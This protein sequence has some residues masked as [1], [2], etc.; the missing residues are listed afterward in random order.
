MQ[1]EPLTTFP[2]EIFPA[3][4][5][6]ADY[7]HN[8]LFRKILSGI[9]SECQTVWNQIRPD[10]LSGLIRFQTVCKSNQQTTLGDLVL[11][12]FVDS[13]RPAPCAK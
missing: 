3:F 2:W 5:L 12:A 11:T 13:K 7:F 9:Q 8:Q 4:L 10:I 1:D 6:P